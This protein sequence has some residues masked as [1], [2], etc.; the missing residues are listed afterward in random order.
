M[1]RLSNGTTIMGFQCSDGVILGADSRATI[2]AFVAIR[3]TNKITQITPNIYVCHSGSASHTQALADYAKYYQNVLNVYEQKT[4]SVHT[5]A[6]VLRKL[7]QANKEM[8][9]AQMIVGGVDDDGPA[10]Y[11][12]MQSGM[13]I[14]REFAI[15][16]SGST[17]ITSYCDHRFHSN[18]SVDEGEQFAVLAINFATIRD[19]YSGGPINIVKITK[20]GVS[21]KWYKPEQQPLNASIVRT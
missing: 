17:Y 9:Q 2:G 19:G 6:L 18:M 5:A 15:G 11:M 3:D 21:R 13:A 4:P 1:Q 14:R 16:G 8:L 7:V 10:V 12:V 20:D